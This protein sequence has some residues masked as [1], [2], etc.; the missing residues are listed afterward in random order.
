MPQAARRPRRRRAAASCVDAGVITPAA[1]RRRRSRRRQARARDRAE[2]RALFHRLGAA[3][4]RHADRRDGSEPLDVWTTLDLGMQ[5]AATAAIQ[6]ECAGRRAGRA[7]RARPRRRGARDGR[8]QGLCRV[9]LQ[10]RDAGDC[11]SRGRR[12]SCSSIS[13]RSRPG[14]KPERPGRRRAGDD[15]RLEPAQL[16]GPLFAA[17]SICAP[18]SPIR[19]TP[20]RRSSATRSASAGRR[21]G[22]PLRHHHAGQHPP[23]DGARQRPTCALIDMTARLCRGRRAR[24]W[25]CTPY[26]ITKVTTANGELLYQHQ[27]DTRHACWSRH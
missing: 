26:G 13:P 8:R 4:A 15:R 25:R 19:S 7:G 6:R 20:S 17:R 22:A 10:P 23:V 9:D 2:Q 21:H 14:Y 27:A 24:A 1:G 3:A 12:S 16:V 5:R 11:A 18:P